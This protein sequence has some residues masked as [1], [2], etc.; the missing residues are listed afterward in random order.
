M[1]KW[2]SVSLVAGTV[3]VLD[4]LTKIAI[5][6]T[7]DLYDSIVVAENYF[8]LVHVLNPGGAFSFLAGSSEAFRFPFFIV[9][10]LIAI[11]ALIVFLR[12]VSEEEHLLLFGLGAILG[13]ALG[14]LCDR[15]LFGAVTDFLDLH[16][17]DYHWPAFNVADSGISVG[18]T[19]LLVYSLFLEEREE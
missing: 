9:V 18:I 13:G 4:Q 11:V 3:F 17:Y 5:R 14:N 12:R 19:I 6:Q 2:S 10:S 15:L 16:W 8:N 1:S 7:I